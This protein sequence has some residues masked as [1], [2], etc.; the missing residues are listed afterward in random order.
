MRY[1]GFEMERLLVALLLSLLL[2]LVVWGGYEGGKKLGWWEKLHQLAQ[3]H[4]A[5]RKIP[6]P[7]P[8]PEMVEPEI[9][10]DVSHPEAEAPKQT[11]YYSNKNSIAA[12]PN[13]SHDEKQPKIEGSQ[14][15]VPKTED[16]PRL[17]K[18][19]PTPP[20]QQPQV[21]PTPQPAPQPEPETPPTK[22]SPLASPMN[23]GDLQLAKL[24]DP[25]ATSQQQQQ[26][27]H[28]RPRTLKVAQA[29]QAKLPGQA[30]KQDG[31]ARRVRQ[32]AALDAKATAF[33][34]Y[35]RAI[36]EAVT[37]HWYALLDSRHFAQDRTGKVILRFKLRYDGSITEMQTL[38]NTVGETLNYV[39]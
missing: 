36:V 14:K 10:V 31:G 29:Q 7:A 34:D 25:T 23:M 11:K 24:T 8:P 28:E 39:C 5:A 3:R 37:D 15:N 4:Q 19:Q 20:P 1:S 9:F 35:D 16:A 17:V 12:N 30:M 18:L 26:Q 38:E 32:W 22:P 2:H 13:A 33:G 6:P 21:K 27:Q